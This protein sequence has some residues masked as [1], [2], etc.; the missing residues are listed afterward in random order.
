LSFVALQVFESPSSFRCEAGLALFERPDLVVQA[1]T[2][3]NALLVFEF[4]GGPP[5][6]VFFERA[7]LYS[8]FGTF[9]VDESVQALDLLFEMLALT[10]HQRERNLDSLLVV[11]EHFRA[12]RKNSSED[13][14]HAVAQ[15]DE[16]PR[17]SRL[18]LER[19]SLAVYFRKNVVD[20]RE[21][22]PGRFE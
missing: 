21:I 3:L 2:A 15:L 7:F 9:L 14:T 18:A 16:P 22:L 12:R 6:A 17:F 8:S 10:C 20:A 1:L 5:F 19:V 4:N 13:F 11:D